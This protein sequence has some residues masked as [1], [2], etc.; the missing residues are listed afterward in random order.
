MNPLASHVF[1]SQLSNTSI[2]HKFLENSCNHI[3]LPQQTNMLGTLLIETVICF[4]LPLHFRV[5]L[6]TIS[7]EAFVL[8]LPKIYFI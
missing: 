6:I 5:L 1:I 8:T 7:L 3:T 4:L 2:K